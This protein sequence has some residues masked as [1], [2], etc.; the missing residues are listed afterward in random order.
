MSRRPVIEHPRPF[1]YVLATRRGIA[2]RITDPWRGIR[3]RC[4]C[5][6]CVKFRADVT[7]HATMVRM[8]IRREDMVASR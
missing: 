5:G 7:A 1:P 6:L 3:A 8:E 4:G 2:V